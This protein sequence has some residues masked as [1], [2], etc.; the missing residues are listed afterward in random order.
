VAAL[1]EEL[2][3][4]LVAGQP[5]PGLRWV[6]DG[7]PVVAA[8]TAVRPLSPKP[9]AQAVRPRAGSGAKVERVEELRS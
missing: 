5:R 6:P 3:R 7:G 8:A 2:C 4:D 9:A 1:T